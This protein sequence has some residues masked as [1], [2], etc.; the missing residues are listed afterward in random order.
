[1]LISVVHFHLGIQSLEHLC[2]Y[3]GL[4]INPTHLTE[5]V[6]S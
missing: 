6:D 3:E 2:E 1:M 4:D 5:Q